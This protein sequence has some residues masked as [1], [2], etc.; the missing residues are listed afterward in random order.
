METI[1]EEKIQ[2]VKKRVIKVEK[3]DANDIKKSHS[4]NFRESY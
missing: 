1:E 4:P 2:Q 3:L